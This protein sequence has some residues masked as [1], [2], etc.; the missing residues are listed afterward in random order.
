M[1]QRGK[2]KSLTA[3]A[4]QAQG[5]VRRPPKVRVFEA[6]QGEQGDEV[7]SRMP[8]GPRKEQEDYRHSGIPIGSDPRE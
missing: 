3:G 1:A 6:G 2:R 8:T 7:M 4:G 5:K